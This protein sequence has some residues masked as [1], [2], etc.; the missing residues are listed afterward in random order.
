MASI[1]D[2]SFGIGDVA[3]GSIIAEAIAAQLS[4]IRF[5]E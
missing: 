1:L 3:Q 2:S 5:P 4:I